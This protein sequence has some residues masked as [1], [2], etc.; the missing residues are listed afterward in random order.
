MGDASNSMLLNIRK[1]IKKLGD[2]LIEVR[3]NTGQDK[4]RSFNYNIV[5]TYDYF[6]LDSYMMLKQFTHNSNDKYET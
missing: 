1:L 6:S 2:F 4:K 5:D 3:A